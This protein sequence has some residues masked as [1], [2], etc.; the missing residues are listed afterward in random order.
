MKMSIARKLGLGFGSVLLIF[1]VCGVATIVQLVRIDGWVMDI[2]WKETPARAAAY[3]MDISMLGSNVEL[4]GYFLDH[5]GTHLDRMAENAA[6]FASAQQEYS[7]VAS[8]EQEDRL[9]KRVAASHGKFSTMSSELIETEKD[10]QKSIAG[11]RRHIEDMDG[12]LHGEIHAS[13]DRAGQQGHQKAAAAYQMEAGLKDIAAALGVFLNTHEG[14][15]N[16]LVRAGKQEFQAALSAYEALALSAQEKE[17]VKELRQLFDEELSSAESIITQEKEQLARMR[18]LEKERNALGSLLTGEVLALTTEHLDS[19]QEATESAVHTGIALTVSLLGISLVAGTIAAV[20]LTR[21]ITRP[22]RAVARRV[23]EI[24]EARGD[25]TAQVPVISEDEVGDLSRS[26]NGML[27]GLRAMVSRILGTS[28]SVSASSQ[29]LSSAAQQTSASVQQVSAAIQQLARGA[30]VQAQRVEETRTAM[31]E[32]STAITQSA[33]AAQA[34]AQVSSRTNESAHKGAEAVKETVVN[35]GK[36]FEST[37]ATSDAVKKLNRRSQQM[38]DIVQVISDVADQ[39]NLLALNAAIEAARAGEAGKGFAVVAE[40][41]RKLA[42]S[43]AKSTTEIG[44]LIRE[45]IGET[46]EAVQTME[47]TFT[48]VSQGKDVAARTDQAIG[49]IL[50]STQDIATMLQQ[51]SASSQQMSAGSKQVEK[52]VEEVSAIAEQSSASTQQASASTQQMVATMQ[53]V[54]ASSQSL[55]EMGVELNTLVAEFKVDGR[56]Q[57]ASPAPGPALTERHGAA[58]EQ[59]LVDA[60]KKMDRSE[61]EDNRRVRVPQQ[62]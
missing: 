58:L 19:D 48:C 4:L 28:E 23:S 11:I 55:A 51:I 46:Q 38:G 59:R 40:E 61:Q 16:A 52:S 9:A 24:A 7:A 42:E 6:G 22:V 29:Q 27:G 44:Q 49:E 18:G 8:S 33:Q 15:Y 62:A 2:R 32:L 50:E 26:F 56:G 21:G 3:E 31:G 45:T 1:T 5:E 36:I 53:E 60:R 41:V 17:H 10:Q 39:T 12:I 34:A 37:R 43:S 13:I 25:L 30:Q 14:D 57:D 35:A 20:R 47:D 54:A